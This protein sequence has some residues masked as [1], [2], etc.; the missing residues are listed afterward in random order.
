MCV[1]HAAV[2]VGVSCGNV[3]CEVTFSRRLSEGMCLR[4]DSSDLNSE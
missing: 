4:Q 2:I 1:Q 3:V